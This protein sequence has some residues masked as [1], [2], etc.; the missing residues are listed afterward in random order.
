MGRF[1]AVVVIGAIVWLILARLVVM[2]SFGRDCRMGGK[3]CFYF[4]A[5]FA[6][7]GMWMS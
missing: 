6:P 1:I 3:G 4:R 7:E 5:L 2:T